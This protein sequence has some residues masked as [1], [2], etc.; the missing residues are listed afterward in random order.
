M[1]G[2][3]GFLVMFDEER[4][5]DLLKEISGIASGFSDTFSSPDWGIKEWEVCF[6]SFDG[7]SLEQACLAKRRNKVAT[8][9]Y[10][11]DFQE[12]VDL[13]QLRLKNITREL[14]SNLERHW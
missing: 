12:F 10:R 9:K 6:L 3:S 8:A 11:V 7:L 4:R 1:A 5:A 14:P 2:Y 13:R